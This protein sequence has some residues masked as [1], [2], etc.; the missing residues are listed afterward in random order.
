MYRKKQINIMKC[1][2]KSILQSNNSTHFFGNSSTMSLS[3]KILTIHWSGELQNVQIVVPTSYDCRILEPMK[4]PIKI[5]TEDL[6][7]NLRPIQ[8]LLSVARAKQERKKKIKKNKTHKSCIAFIQ[9]LFLHH[10]AS[11]NTELKYV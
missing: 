11:K 2:N 9:S 1:T 3:N 5:L 8:N 6:V 4:W 10:I 7:M